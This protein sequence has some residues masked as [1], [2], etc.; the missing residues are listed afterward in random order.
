MRF[1]KKINQAYRRNKIIYG[2]SRT[3]DWLK[4]RYF[5][6]KDAA[7][8]RSFAEGLGT[9]D[10]S[11]FCFAIAFNTPWVIDALTK[12]WQQYSSGSILVVVDNSNSPAARQSIE[13]IC[14]IRGVPYF[15]LPGNP[16][17]HRSR[18]NG[19]AMNWIYYNIVRHLKPKAFGFLDHDCLPIA[20]LISLSAWG[21]KPPME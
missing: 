8:G 18:S 21:A 10:E 19:I 3:R 5:R 11:F 12:G 20:P 14:K 4:Y 17:R 16:E 1:S 7:K 15:G 2:A 6:L 13:K 9:A